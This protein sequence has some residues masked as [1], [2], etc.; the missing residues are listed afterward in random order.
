MIETTSMSKSYKMPIL[1]AFYNKGNIKM[2]IDEEDVY[3]SFYEFYHKGSNKVDM[4]R[5]KATSDFE[6]WDKKKYIKLAKENPIKFLLKSHGDF[7][8]VKE[9]ALIA[10]HDDMK[11]IIKNKAFAEH[12]KDAIELRVDKYYKERKL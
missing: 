4:L 9:G 3:K 7:F 1:L 2:E 11:D 8:K 5:H 10:L 6:S 12:M